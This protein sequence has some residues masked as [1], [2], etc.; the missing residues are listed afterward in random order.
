MTNN[1]KNNFLY[2]Y[3]AC[4]NSPSIIFINFIDAIGKHSHGSGG[5]GGSS[6]ECD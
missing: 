2:F 1:Y 4:M 3:M 6:D 5:G